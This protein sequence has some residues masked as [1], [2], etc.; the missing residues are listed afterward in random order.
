MQSTFITPKPLSENARQ[1]AQHKFDHVAKPLNSLGRF[2]S[3]IPVL[4]SFS[5]VITASS[6]RAS[7]SAAVM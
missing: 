5:A 3:L 4:S 7:P 1:M 6:G 2:E